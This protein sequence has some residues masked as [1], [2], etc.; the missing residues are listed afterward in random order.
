M[1]D[2]HIRFQQSVYVFSG[3]KSIYCLMSELFKNK[4]RVSSARLQDWDYGW[5]GAYFITICTKD[6]E[7]LFGDIENGV[8]KL[9]GTGIIANILWHEIKNHAT[10]IELGAFIV[11][12]NHV[13]GIII[14]NADD[15][16]N[17]E[18]GHG[19]FE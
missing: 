4:Y 13:H 7:F 1:R 17:V 19:D 15:D 9:S 8:M 6:R 3:G 18:T 10:G 11:M 16:L 2:S 12:P 14:I 5:N